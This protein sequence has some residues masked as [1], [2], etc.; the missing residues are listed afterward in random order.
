M[1]GRQS[2]V[3]TGVGIVPR[4]VQ[5]EFDREEKKIEQFETTNHAD[6][7]LPAALRNDVTLLPHQHEGLAWLQKRYGLQREGMSGCLLADDMGL[8]KTLQSLCL[9]DRKSVV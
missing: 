9:I 6:D 8:G 3:S 4:A 2:L 1:N 7:C 5:I